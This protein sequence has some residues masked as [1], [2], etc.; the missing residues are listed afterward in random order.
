MVTSG[1]VIDIAA[2]AGTGGVVEASPDAEP[3]AA[4]DGD[5]ATGA[6]GAD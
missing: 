4:V 3:L 5:V 1:G 6:A 2:R